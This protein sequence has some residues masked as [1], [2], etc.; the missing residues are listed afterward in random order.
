MSAQFPAHLDLEEEE[1]LEVFSKNTS[2]TDGGPSSP[3]SM[4]NQYREEEEEELFITIDHPESHVTAIETFITYRVMTK[5]SRSDFDCS[6]FE[7][8]RRYQDFLWLRSTLEENHPT[9]IVH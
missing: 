6:E 2:L 7:V 4:M 3:S 8:R 1:D 9:L 5:T